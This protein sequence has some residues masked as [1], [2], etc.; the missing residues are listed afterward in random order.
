M[1]ETLTG[2][3]SK[4]AGS[5]RVWLSK[6]AY[7]DE[8]GFNL[9]SLTHIDDRARA[10]AQAQWGVVR[11]RGAGRDMLPSP[12][13]SKRSKT[14][15][16][17]GFLRTLPRTAGAET[18]DGAA[19]FVSY[20]PFTMDP[21]DGLTKKS[22]WARQWRSLS[23]FGSPAVRNPGPVSGSERAAGA[24][25]YGSATLMAARTCTMSRT[26]RFKASHQGFAPNS[27][28]TG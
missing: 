26:P 27:L 6:A 18:N 7:G 8:V 13:S 24:N 28:A 3:S 21:D 16:L 2:V 4:S 9:W 22:R 11:V 14:Q 12:P 15:A 5:K 17:T 1:S 23:R 19:G 20:G 10:D 25:R